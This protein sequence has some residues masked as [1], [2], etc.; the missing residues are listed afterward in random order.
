MFISVALRHPVQRDRVEIFKFLLPL[1]SDT[2]LTVGYERRFVKDAGRD[3]YANGACKEVRESFQ[4]RFVKDAGK[5][6]YANGNCKKVRESFQ[7]NLFLHSLSHTHTL[8]VR[9]VMIMD[10]HTHT[11]TN[12]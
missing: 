1:G 4:R 6:R 9:M 5:G 3:R 12:C 11:L 8:I 7:Y 10:T 2:N